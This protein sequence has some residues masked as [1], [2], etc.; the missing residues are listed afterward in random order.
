MPLIDMFKHAKFLGM[1][2]FTL[3]GLALAATAS[4]RDFAF[5]G[6]TLDLQE[7]TTNAD[8]YYTAMRYNR[9]AAEWDVNVTVSNKTSQAFSG[10]LVLLI[11]S[12]TGTA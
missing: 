12:Y 11:D 1:I 2:F 9:A 5:G 3:A 10:P 6:V 7:I 4:G 8:V